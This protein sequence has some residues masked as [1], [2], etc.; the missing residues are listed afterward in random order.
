MSRIQYI[1]QL[2]KGS[3]LYNFYIHKP[4]PCLNL[5]LIAIISN[6]LL[7]LMKM[8]LSSQSLDVIFKNIFEKNK[9]RIVTDIFVNTPNITSKLYRHNEKTIRND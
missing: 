4:R 3:D 7:K 8:H 1:S 9:S 5:L 6:I 2:R